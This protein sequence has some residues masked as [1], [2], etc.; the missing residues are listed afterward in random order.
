M[1]SGYPLRILLTVKNEFT[2]VFFLLRC[3]DF[4]VDDSVPR[5]TNIFLS[6]IT[7]LLWFRIF[8]TCFQHLQK[9][10]WTSDFF[11]APREINRFLPVEERSEPDTLEWS[12]PAL[13]T[14]RK[15]K[16]KE[17]LDRRGKPEGCGGFE[18]GGKDL[19]FKMAHV[20]F[21]EHFSKCSF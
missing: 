17:K 21:R 12:R 1:V 2:V 7:H 6:P 5:Q 11:I 15:R 13:R 10:W 19:I 16:S 4:V 14:H 3:H 9:F 18:T 8:I 20:Y